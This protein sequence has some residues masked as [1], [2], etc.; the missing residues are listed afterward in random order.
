MSLCWS[1]LEFLSAAL[2]LMCVHYRAHSN[3]DITGIHAKPSR[4]HILRHGALYAHWEFERQD[5]TANGELSVAGRSGFDSLGYW[6]PNWLRSL[7]FAQTLFVR[8][9][10]CLIAPLKLEHKYSAKRNGSF[11]ICSTWSLYET[12]RGVSYTLTSLSEKC[13]SLGQPS[14]VAYDHTCG[15]VRCDMWICNR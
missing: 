9:I 2:L 6:Y 4:H 14:C 15:R 12:T 7:F 13:L 3:I 8:E 10:L 1:L 11:S 5:S